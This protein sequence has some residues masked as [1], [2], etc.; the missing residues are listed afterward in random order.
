MAN[1]KQGWLSGNPYLLI[2][3]GV[4][5]GLL[6]AG[7]ILLLAG[8]RRGQ[9][10]ELLPPPESAPVTVHVSGGVVQPGVYELPRGSRVQDALDAA[11]GPVDEADLDRINLARVLQDGQQIY[12]PLIGED[13]VESTRFP[14]NINVATAEQLSLLPG[15]GEVTAQAIVDYREAQGPFDRIEDIQDVAGIGPSTFETIK[16]LISVEG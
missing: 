12:V 15:I 9:V 10:V 3:F 8:P 6:A 4:L 2:A 16:E 13:S 7:L 1:S 11:G 14:I 5:I